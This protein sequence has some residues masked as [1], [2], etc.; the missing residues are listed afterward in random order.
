MNKITSKLELLRSAQETAV[1]LLDPKLN[2]RQRTDLITQG[3][4][5]LGIDAKHFDQFKDWVYEE[6]Y[7]FQ[8][9]A[10]VPLEPTVVTTTANGTAATA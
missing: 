3:F 1:K 8:Q 2:T 6:T 4:D 10:R 7:K 9:L 5:A